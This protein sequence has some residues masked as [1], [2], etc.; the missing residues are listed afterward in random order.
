MYKV[1]YKFDLT[2]SLHG[3]NYLSEQENLQVLLYID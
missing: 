2:L 1:H 3:D